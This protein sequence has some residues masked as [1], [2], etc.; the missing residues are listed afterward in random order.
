MS[1]EYKFL[2]DGRLRSSAEP[3][4]IR[5]PYDGE[6]A[7]VTWRAGAA[8]VEDAIEAARKAFEETR[9]W[10][11]FRR[12]EL[13]EGI[14]RLVRERQE[15][16]ARL[17]VLEAG[18]P[19]RL[20]RA[21]VNRAIATLTDAVEEAKRVRGEWLPLDLDRSMEGRHALVRRFPVGPV[22]AITPFNFPLNLAI[23]KLAPALACGNTMVIKPA[24]QAP[25]SVLALAQAV[26]EA[27]A[28]PGL[29]G[30]LFCDVE[31]ARAMVTDPR[32]KL[33]SFTGSAG[34]GW[35]LKRAA[36]K[37]RV[38]LELGGNAGVAVHSDAD[39]DLAARRC[40]YGG[41]AFAGQ[42]C[43]SVQRIYA[44]RSV[45]DL[46][47]ARLLEE[48][49]KLKVGN[50]LDETTDLG[51]MISVREAERAER[52][53]REA[54]LGGATVLHGGQRDRGTLQPTVLTGTNRRMSVCCQEIF[55][56][57]VV[58]EPYDDL[59]QALSLL[60]DSAYGLQAGLFTRDV[61]VSFAAFEDLEVGG[62]VLNDVPTFRADSMPYGGVKDSGLGRE[63]VRYAIEE[64]TERK[65]LVFNLR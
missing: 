58:L 49:G 39:V 12:V 19:I 55:A 42:T 41:F 64:M 7:G 29:L 61:S 33:L 31:D 4:E 38:V 14:L 51:P 26:T 27:G 25:L 2:V 60:N 35:D 24:P 13:I 36:G 37:K 3:V 53:V 1:Q 23:H 20:A 46:F 9:R 34:V 62:L 57:V 56:P 43:I 5:S 65:T 11:T 32:V 30:A 50:P 47:A 28:P 52:W 40:A 16:F 18:K 48:V 10:P 21:E 6:L 17:I 63:G 59:P 15:S 54:V 45:F 22:A 8:D 44:H